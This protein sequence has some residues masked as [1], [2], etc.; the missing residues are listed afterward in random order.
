METASH[1]YFYLDDVP[2]T[3]LLVNPGFENSISKATG[4]TT[5]A[6]GCCLSYAIQIIAST[7]HSDSNCLQYQCGPENS[8]SF[9]GQYFTATMGH[10]YNISYYLEVTGSGAQPTFYAVNVY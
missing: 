2:S 4:W 10:T 7:S 5:Q 1:R 3:Q 9:F 6:G 8:Y